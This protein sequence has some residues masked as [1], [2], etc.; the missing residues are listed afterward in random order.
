M[1]QKNM[2][3]YNF[4]H[5]QERS[6]LCSTSSSASISEEE[7]PARVAAADGSGSS[8]YGTARLTQDLS[9]LSVFPTSSGSGAEDSSSVLSSAD[10]EGNSSL[11]SSGQKRKS[12]PNEGSNLNK[13][14]AKTTANERE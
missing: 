7:S 4:F 8:G 1:V 3:F 2:L 6:M 5:L 9:G 12:T 13:W 14:R 10:S 11:D